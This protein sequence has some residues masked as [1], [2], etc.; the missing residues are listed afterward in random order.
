MYSDFKEKINFL[1]SEII[2][3]HE[4]TDGS[5][6]QTPR[7]DFIHQNKLLDY[8]TFHK[9]TGEPLKMD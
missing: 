9:E 8:V 1:R 5:R 6:K 7:K 3:E 4:T 2:F